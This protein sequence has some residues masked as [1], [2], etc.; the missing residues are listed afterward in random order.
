M[1]RAIGLESWNSGVVIYIAI[2]AAACFLTLAVG[3]PDTL[4]IG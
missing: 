1:L 2:N 3:V 4:L